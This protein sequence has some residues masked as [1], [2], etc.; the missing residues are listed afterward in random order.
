MAKTQPA[1]VAETLQIPGYDGVETWE[2]IVNPTQPPVLRK[3]KINMNTEEMNKF[4]GNHDVNLYF[5]GGKIPTWIKEYGVILDEDEDETKL[6]R[7]VIPQ[8]PELILFKH[9]QQPLYNILVPKPLSE[10]EISSDGDIVDQAYY[11]DFRAIAFGGSNAPRNY[12]KTY[13]KARVT[14]IG[15]NLQKRSERLK[16]WRSHKELA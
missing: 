8:F 15:A 7:S 16:E 5:R 10:F 14:V 11:A 13:F 12:D 4:F 1:V 6:L 9:K 3:A 2:E